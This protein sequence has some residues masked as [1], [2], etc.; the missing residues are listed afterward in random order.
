MLTDGAEMGQQI[1]ISKPGGD[2]CELI[3]AFCHRLWKPS[4]GLSKGVVRWGSDLER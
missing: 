2:P 4:Q 1:I 3:Q